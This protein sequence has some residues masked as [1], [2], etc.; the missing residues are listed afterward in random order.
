MVACSHWQRGGA[1]GEEGEGVRT[2]EGQ[3][4]ER[5]SDEEEEERCVSKG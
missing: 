3:V 1:G 4:K 2:G 5:G